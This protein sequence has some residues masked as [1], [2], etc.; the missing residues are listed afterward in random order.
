MLDRFS[1]FRMENIMPRC[2]DRNG[3][4]YSSFYKNWNIYQFSNNSIA[5]IHAYILL[6]RTL[7]VLHCYMI[8]LGIYR[9]ESNNAYMRCDNNSTM[10]AAVEKFHWHCCLA[11]CKEQS[12]LSRVLGKKHRR[13]CVCNV[14]WYL[15]ACRDFFFVYVLR[16]FLDPDDVC[17]SPLRFPFF[18]D[19][20]YYHLIYFIE[21]QYSRVWVSKPN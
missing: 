5:H 18:S 19:N 12:F 1:R 4:I 17:V 7:N 20:F 6:I 11:F 15:V 9:T 10:K 3:K 16:I 2:D 8:N 13:M 21:F 14:E